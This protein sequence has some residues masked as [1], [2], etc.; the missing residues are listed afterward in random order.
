MLSIEAITWVTKGVKFFFL[1]LFSF[2]LISCNNNYHLFLVENKNSS[3]YFSSS[4]YAF[5]VSY[6]F[7]GCNKIFSFNSFALA[8]HEY[9]SF[10][11][12][13]SCTLLS[14]IHATLSCIQ[15]FKVYAWY[16]GVS[17]VCFDVAKRLFNVSCCRPTI[18]TTRTTNQPLTVFC[19]GSN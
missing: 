3:S 7:V 11:A 5:Y 19:F 9:F 16:V 10:I 2:H 12:T 6:F 4:C 17:E 14:L 1:F 15:N 18:S 13:F 8:W